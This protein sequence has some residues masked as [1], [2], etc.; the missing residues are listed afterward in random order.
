M[1]QDFIADNGHQHIQD[2]SGLMTGSHDN[3]TVDFVVIPPQIIPQEEGAEGEAQHEMG[4]LGI[5]AFQLLMEQVHIVEGAFPATLAKGCT[6]GIAGILTMTTQVKTC[7]GNAV[8]RQVF[9]QL[10]IAAHVIGHAVD[11]LHHQGGGTDGSVDNAGKHH[12][13][14]TDELE[15][16][17]SHRLISLS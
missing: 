12:A 15:L 14:G 10:Q 8:I 5:P 4:S 16:V 17:Y 13:V 2:E 11:D 6:L 3:G 9:S 7:N 1:G